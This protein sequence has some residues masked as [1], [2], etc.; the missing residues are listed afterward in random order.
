MDC[1]ECGGDLQA[2]P[3]PAD[4]RQHLPGEEPGAALCARCL[5]LQPVDDP[6]AD[7]PD[8]REISDAFPANSDA[9]VPMAIAVGLLSSLALYRQEIAALLETVERAGSDPLLV[10]DRL[11]TDPDLDPHVDLAGR[12][13]QLERLIE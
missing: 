12:R 13:R 11:A 10:I 5:A 6:P 8:F 2:F 9:A 1:P 4:L 7:P 3:V